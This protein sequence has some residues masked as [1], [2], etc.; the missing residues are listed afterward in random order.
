MKKTLLSLLLT[1]L[2]LTSGIAV[3]SCGDNNDFDNS[4]HIGEKP[5]INQI[6]KNRNFTF[7]LSFKQTEEEA[8]NESNVKSQLWSKLTNQ[9]PQIVNKPEYFELTINTI[10]KT[11]KISTTNLNPIF[12]GSVDLEYNFLPYELATPKTDLG[13]IKIFNSTPEGNVDNNII[14]IIKTKYTDDLTNKYISS[15]DDFEYNGT[16]KITFKIHVANK[17]VDSPKYK[18]GTYDGLATYW[19]KGNLENI[20]GD[21]NEIKDDIQNETELKNLIT[22]YVNQKVNANYVTFST[23]FNDINPKTIEVTSKD[24]HYSGKFAITFT[25][26]LGVDLF[27]NRPELGTT[28]FDN[29]GTTAEQLQ[30]R[31]IEELKKKDDTFK[32]FWNINLDNPSFSN[33]KEI[34]DNNGTGSRKKEIKI[35][36]NANTNLIG[37]FDLTARSE[38][39]NPILI[40]KK[41]IPNISVVN[42]NG[43]SAKSF[44]PDFKTIEDVKKIVTDKLQGFEIVENKDS[45]YI[46]FKGKAGTLMGTESLTIYNDFPESTEN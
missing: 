29:V 9:N 16:N 21:T 18:S 24:E 2:T 46:I 45:K 23:K 42:N 7:N 30:N 38:E 12:V 39:L 35:T 4:F 15:I 14:E 10:E 5:N 13:E 22:S 37:N 32:T 40:L 1:G 20:F 8:N 3:V 31:I 27:S 25:G 34:N 28:F 44:G 11:A 33:I 26:K 41:D 17:G 6:I 36:I 43:V 19:V